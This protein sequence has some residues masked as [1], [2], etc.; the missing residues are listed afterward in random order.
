MPY[1]ALDVLTLN[2]FFTTMADY[3]SSAVERLNSAV[4][5]QLYNL[6]Q[7]LLM[8]IANCRDCWQGLNGITDTLKH[9]FLQYIPALSLQLTCM[10][11]VARAYI[12]VSNRE[13]AHSSGQTQKKTTMVAKP[14]A[15]S[16]DQVRGSGSGQRRTW[17][18]HVVPR[19]PQGRLD[20]L[21]EVDAMKQRRPIICYKCQK[22]GHI[23]RDCRSQINFNEMDWSE[24]WALVLKEE[25]G[26]GKAQEFVEGSSKD[27]QD[28]SD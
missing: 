1:I 2:Y 11:F 21:M 13:K 5:L 7:G 22:P 27:F 20:E 17:D 14:R 28:G 10:F 25:K 8:A 6:L 4:T 23:T 16:E 24:I 19:P 15:I 3:I 9:L 18:G 26:K 12:S